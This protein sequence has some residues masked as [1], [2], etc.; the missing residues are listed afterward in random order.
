MTITLTLILNWCCLPKGF[1]INS[2]REL[3]ISIIISIIFN[4]KFL[5][6]CLISVDSE[7]KFINC[8]ICELSETESGIAIMLLVKRSYLFQVRFKY[9]KSMFIINFWGV[10]TFILS[11]PLQIERFVWILIRQERYSILRGY[12]VVQKYKDKEWRD[13]NN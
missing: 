6:I 1:P 13:A 12:W 11:K 10:D 7:F 9:I 3:Y 8:K 4:I 2:G 5:Y